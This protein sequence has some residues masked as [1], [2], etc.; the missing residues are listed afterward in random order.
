MKRYLS[1]LALAATITMGFSACQKLDGAL[2]TDSEAAPEAISLTPLTYTPTKA[3]VYGTT[4]PDDLSI[5]ATAYFNS[6]TGTTAGTK[7]FDKVKFD[8]TTEGTY[9]GKWIPQ[10][11]YYWPVQGSLSMYAIVYNKNS[12]GTEYNNVTATFPDTDNKTFS[13]K[14]DSLRA[15][16]DILIG[17]NR[18]AK[19]TEAGDK[20]T[21]YHISSLIE[22]QMAS[23]ENFIV[24]T[25]DVT[26]K[27]SGIAVTGVKI[28]TIYQSITEFNATRDNENNTFSFT[29]TASGTQADREIYSGDTIR[30]YKAPAVE[31]YTFGKKKTEFTPEATADN[32]GNRIIVPAQTKTTMT[33]K[34][35]LYNGSDGNASPELTCTVTLPQIDTQTDHTTEWLAG[36]KY[37]YKVTIG[38]DKITI[39]PDV[40][41]WVNTDVSVPANT[42]VV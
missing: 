3:I 13:V 41:D 21:F 19:K 25:G 30:L 2:K 29:P 37:T 6:N 23:S 22:V 14:V 9:S 35:K 40:S 8:K 5:H 34:Y 11:T 38:L 26:D 1:V 39:V 15:D 24:Q 28:D 16:Q 42:P 7:Y 10:Y 27:M 33:I 4:F 36:K 20:M 18:D 17:A 32:K 12:E 31:M